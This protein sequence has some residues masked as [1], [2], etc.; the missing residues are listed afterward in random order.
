MTYIIVTRN[1]NSKRLVVISDGD[2]D[3]DDPPAMEYETHEAAIEGP[4][5]F[6]FAAHGDSTSLRLTHSWSQ[7]AMSHL[8]DM[9]QTKRSS[10]GASLRTVGKEARISAAQLC[11][12][13]R[14]TET[15]PCVSTLL[16]IACALE[17]NPHELFAEVLLDQPGVTRR[18]HRS[19]AE[20][21]AVELEIC[22]YDKG[23]ANAPT[24]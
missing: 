15:N 5:R 4:I 24:A 1:P 19:E 16:G 18:Q 20:R 14:G 17:I 3:G 8:G 12:I 9:V 23:A 6:L 11:Q 22:E 21:H 2:V 13:E 10:M 7:G